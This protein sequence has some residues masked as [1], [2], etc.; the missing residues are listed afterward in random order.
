[1]ATKLNDGT[2]KCDACPQIFVYLKS[3]KTNLYSVPTNIQTVS[4]EDLQLLKVR[5]QTHNRDIDVFFDK[6]KGHIS[7]FSDCPAAKSFRKK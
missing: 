7:H 5:E 3:R 6:T 2:F 4:A 1:M